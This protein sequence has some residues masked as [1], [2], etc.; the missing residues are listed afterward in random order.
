[1]TEEQTCFIVTSTYPN[2][3]Q[4]AH[5]LP[6]SPNRILDTTL[7][8]ILD[9]SYAEKAKRSQQTSPLGMTG[10]TEQMTTYRLLTMVVSVRSAKTKRV[11]GGRIGIFSWTM[12][13]LWATTIS[14]RQAIGR[15]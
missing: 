3:V 5:V 8:W 12:Y 2:W 1:M 15:Y 6:D 9:R 14:L 4:K 10:K 13:C 11:N 7:H